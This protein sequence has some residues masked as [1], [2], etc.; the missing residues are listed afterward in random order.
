MD[1]KKKQTNEK[2]PKT[3]LTIEDK[4]DKVFNDAFI[5]GSNE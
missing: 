3:N 1:A 2:K 4:M 5:V